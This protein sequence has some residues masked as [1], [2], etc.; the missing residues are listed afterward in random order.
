MSKYNKLLN[1]HPVLKDAFFAFSDKAFAESLK[2]RKLNKE[3]IYKGG[4]GLYGTKEGINA[5]YKFYEDRTARIAK[6]C[7]PQEVYDYEYDNH[8]CEYTEDD[9]DAITIVV[10]IFGSDRSEEVNRR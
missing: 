4:S 6:E 10:D 1:E 8:E 5:V 9:T 3:D 2:E 7:T